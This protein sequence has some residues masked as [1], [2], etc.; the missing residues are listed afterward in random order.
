[1]DTM[2]IYKHDIVFQEVP[3]HISLSISVCGCPLRCPGCHSAE[4]WKA[5]NGYP[6]TPE[7]FENL[8]KQYSRKITCV[9]FLGGEWQEQSL[10]KF[11]ARAQKENLKTALYTGLDEISENIKQH[12]NFLKTG[13]WR[14][15]LGGLSSPT[16]NQI[17]RDLNTNQILNHLFL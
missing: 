10:V 5:D 2:N 17:F 13:P 1:M 9:L 3:D 12:L 4:L 7:L 14:P 6:L 15:D 11:L 16:T 8:L